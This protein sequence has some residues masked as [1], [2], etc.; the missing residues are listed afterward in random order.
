MATTEYSTTPQSADEEP[1]R[2]TYGQIKTQR[3]NRPKKEISL[4]E[5]EVVPTRHSQRISNMRKSRDE[6]VRHI[7]IFHRRLQNK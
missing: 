6:Q 3:W 5:M 2:N 7:E 1:K 4:K